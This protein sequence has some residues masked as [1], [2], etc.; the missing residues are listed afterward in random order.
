FGGAQ[1]PDKVG[2]ANK[3]KL[4]GVWEAVK[5]PTFPK[6]TTVQFT[7]EGKITV[8]FREGGQTATLEMEYTVTGNTIR[9]SFKD[10]ENKVTRDAVTIKTLTA[11]DLVTVGKDGKENE[12]KK[13]KKK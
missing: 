10:P 6:G 2:A 8:I 11:T 13:Q 4:L 3:E 12:F 7:K 9:T 5:G 1:P